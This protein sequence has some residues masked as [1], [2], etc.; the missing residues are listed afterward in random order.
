MRKGDE[1]AEGADA[2][3]L[4]LVVS[5]LERVEADNSALAKRVTELEAAL[6]TERD[7]RRAVEQELARIV[8]S[9]KMTNASAQATKRRHAPRRH[10]WQ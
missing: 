6:C 8:I 5:R 10:T 4:C 2:C 7:G 3:R 1:V 9:E